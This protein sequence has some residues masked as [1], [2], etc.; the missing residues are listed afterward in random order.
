MN[1]TNAT[2]HDILSGRRSISLS[3]PV[4]GGI[5]IAIIICTC[6][7]TLCA[8]YKCARIVNK[9][10]GRRKKEKYF[11]SYIEE[12]RKKLRKKRKKKRPVSP[13]LAIGTATEVTAPIIPKEPERL[14]DAS[15]TPCYKCYRKKKKGR[16]RQIRR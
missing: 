11:P 15:P 7:C 13:D 16:K 3:L 1:N 14:E 5:I 8:R 9:L 4:A 6:C 10:T 12:G 2:I